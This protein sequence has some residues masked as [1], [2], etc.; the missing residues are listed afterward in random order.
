[1]RRSTAIKPGLSSSTTEKW[2]GTQVAGCTPE[3]MGIGPAITIF[4]FLD[5]TGLETEDVG[6]W[7]INEAFASQAILSLEVRSPRTNGE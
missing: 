3:E 7:E 6:H 2:A 4:K 5:F 1:M